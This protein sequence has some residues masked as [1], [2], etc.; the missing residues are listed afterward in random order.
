MWAQKKSLLTFFRV[1]YVVYISQRKDWFHFEERY[2]ATA[3]KSFEDQK[4]LQRCSRKANAMQWVC[5][6]ASICKPTACQKMLA[7]MLLQQDGRRESLLTEKVLGSIFPLSES[8][9]DSVSDTV[10]MKWPYHKQR[11]LTSKIW[12]LILDE[13]FLLYSFSKIFGRH[14]DPNWIIW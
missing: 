8:R 10:V 12:T 6:Q 1:Y 13:N 9:F 7:P 3:T 11:L 2:L 14:S 5:L 4:C